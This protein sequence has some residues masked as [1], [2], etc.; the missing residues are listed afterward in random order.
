MQRKTS[1]AIQRSGVL[2]DQGRELVVAS[3]YTRGGSFGYFVIREQKIGE[4]YVYSDQALF[5]KKIS[6]RSYQE[7]LNKLKEL[8][9]SNP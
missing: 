5:V 7:A 1:I 6:E 2:D 8:A 9:S 4:Q 3:G